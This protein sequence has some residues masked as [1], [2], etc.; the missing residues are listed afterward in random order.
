[1]NII[2]RKGFKCAEIINLSVAPYDLNVHI[3]K[4]KKNVIFYVLPYIEKHKYKEKKTR[5][6]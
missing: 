3:Y 5:E 2:I 6:C 4:L 1:M